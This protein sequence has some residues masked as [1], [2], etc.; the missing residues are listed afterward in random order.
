MTVQCSGEEYFTILDVQNLASSIAG[1][2]LFWTEGSTQPA[3]TVLGSL[4]IEA[5]LEFE[6]YSGLVTNPSNYFT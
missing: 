2:C 4:R 3:G 5:Q 6:H 1:Y